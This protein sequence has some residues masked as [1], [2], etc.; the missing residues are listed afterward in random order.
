MK[1]WLIGL[2][3]GC[4]ALAFAVLAAWALKDEPAF[5]DDWRGGWA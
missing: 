4:A 1:R 3:V 2:S 5:G